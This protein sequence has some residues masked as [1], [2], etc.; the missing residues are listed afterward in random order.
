MEVA[1]RELKAK[2]SAYLKRAAAGEVITVT[3]RGRP[4][5]SLG[6]VP[7]RVD[8]TVGV[9]EGWIT[10]AVREG[11]APAARHRSTGTV[12]QVLAEDRVE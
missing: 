7:G 10:P 2:L 3:E 4:I 11:L 6:P 9:D 1:V 12:H 8:L 5:A